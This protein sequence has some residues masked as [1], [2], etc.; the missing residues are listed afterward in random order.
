MDRGFIDSSRRD[1]NKK[2][3]KK[4]NTKKRGTEGVVAKETR[5]RRRGVTGRE[6]DVVDGWLRCGKRR[7]RGEW[8]RERRGTRRVRRGTRRTYRIDGKG[9]RRK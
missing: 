7:D 5:L 3:D 8:E 2:E 4:R 9:E 6:E 1:G